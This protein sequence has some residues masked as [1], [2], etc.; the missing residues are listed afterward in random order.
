[1]RPSGN[2]GRWQALKR[3]AGEYN[4]NKPRKERAKENEMGTGTMTFHYEWE[5]PG[6]YAPRAVENH[7][8]FFCCGGP[9]DREPNTYPMGLG[10][11]EYLADRPSDH[12]N[13]PEHYN[14]MV[15]AMTLTPSGDARGEYVTGESPWETRW[16]TLEG[17]VNGDNV[18]AVFYNDPQEIPA[19]WTLNRLDVNGLPAIDNTDVARAI[20]ARNGIDW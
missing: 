15:L 13:N 14:V 6:W 2:A 19:G 8:T 10:T 9:Y 12:D 7:V 3:R 16:V 5:G 20:A 18:R 11:P 1:M 4:N 17:D